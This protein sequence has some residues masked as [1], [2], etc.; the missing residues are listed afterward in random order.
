MPLYWLPQSVAPYLESSV[1]ID[2]ERFIYTALNDFI[3]TGG[4]VDAVRVSERIEVTTAEDV[5]RAERR[6]APQ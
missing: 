4:V 1:P 5:H 3:A 6:L 2:G